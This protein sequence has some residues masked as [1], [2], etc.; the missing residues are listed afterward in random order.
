MGPSAPCGAWLFDSL[1]SLSRRLLKGYIVLRKLFCILT[2]TIFIFSGATA[3]ASG[4]PKAKP[5]GQQQTVTVHGRAGIS[6]SKR[7]CKPASLIKKSV[8]K[9]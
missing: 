1:F 6:A 9:F 3:E 5:Q 8:H 7:C 4:K 2:A